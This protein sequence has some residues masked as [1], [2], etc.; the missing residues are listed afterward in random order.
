MVTTEILLLVLVFVSVAGLSLAVTGYFVPHPVQARLR[1]IAGDT[2]D[3]EP[4]SENAWRN[5][6]IEA[7][8][9]AGKLSLPKEGWEKSA[10]RQRFMHA[11]FRGDKAPV[12]F[13]A[14]KTLLAFALPLTFM[15]YAGISRVPM[16]FNLVLAVIV[17]LAAVGYYLPNLYLRQCIDRRQREIFETFPDAIDLMTVAVEAGLGLDAAIAR[18]GQ[19]MGVKSRALEEE[20]H[21]V[22]LELRAGAARDQALRNLALRT[23]VA[24][25]E[26]FVVMLVQSDRFGT[27]MADSLRVHSDALRTKRRLRAEE[28]AAKIALKLL[29][30]LVFCI[31]PSMMLVLVGPAAIS[32]YRVL[33]P[34]A[35]GS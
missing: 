3:R 15:L 4:G 5:R 18:V 32:I 11:G 33:F 20:I 35:S 26:L 14:A 31:F 12:L 21:L 7:V 1:K 8:S 23:G 6:I 9:P 28:A 22:G 17:G 34:I 27:S 16:G 10:L 25:V 2:G 30:P 24:E 29:F 19:E 13:F